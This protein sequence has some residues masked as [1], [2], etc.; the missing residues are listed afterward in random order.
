MEQHKLKQSSTTRQTAYFCMI[1]RYIRFPFI[2]R[3][4]LNVK[5]CGITTYCDSCTRD[6]YVRHYIDCRK[7]AILHLCKDLAVTSSRGIVVTSWSSA[8]RLF[9]MWWLAALFYCIAKINAFVLPANM[10]GMWPRIDLQGP[11]VL[12]AKSML[13]GIVHDVSVHDRTPA[14]S[15][16]LLHFSG[17]GKKLTG[18]PLNRER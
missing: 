17:K 12:I 8:I 13:T 15:K 14:F 1:S 11:Q 10:H 9:L 7:P 4:I 2:A 6:R 18:F 3:G 16:V 5:W